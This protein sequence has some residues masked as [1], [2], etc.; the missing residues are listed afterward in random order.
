MRSVAPAV[1]SRLQHDRKA[2]TGGFL[3]VAGLLC[4][5]ALPV[6]AL[7]SG[8]SVATIGFI[9]GAR[10]L[11]AAQALVWLGLLAGLRIFFE[12]VYDYFVVLAKSRVVLVVQVVWLVALIPALLV[13]SRMRGIFG[14]GMAGAAVAA[15]V[16]L[17]WYLVE[18]RHVGIRLRSLAA[19]LLLPLGG[20]AVAGLA[21]YAI[22][23]AV[24]SDLLALAASGIA[25]VLVIGL[26]IYRMR[27]ALRLLRPA[28]G[29]PRAV[30][31]RIAACAEAGV[32]FASGGEPSV[33]VREAAPQ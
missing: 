28:A 5:V 24:A 2:M 26:L 12:L 4:A 25:T 21:A 16:V 31:D 29:D 10:W 6:C 1:F 19:R 17:P 20:A 18:L 33:F 8:S 15:A 11:P 32:R 23:R 9:Y 7:L 13:G 30:V 14:A 22:R 3:N 27:S